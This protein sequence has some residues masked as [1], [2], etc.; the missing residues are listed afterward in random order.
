MREKYKRVDALALADA[1]PTL[2]MQVITYKRGSKDRSG[3]EKES[4][5]VEERSE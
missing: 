3:I 5:K 4:N 1:I 2:T